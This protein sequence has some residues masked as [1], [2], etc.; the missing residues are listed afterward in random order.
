MCLWTAVKH[1]SSASSQKGEALAPSAPCALPGK[2]FQRKEEKRRGRGPRWRKGMGKDRERLEGEGN[3]GKV[4]SSSSALSL[5]KYSKQLC[6]IS[7]L[8]FLLA[9]CEGFVFSGACSQL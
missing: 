2:A 9:L 1:V 5:C 4:P 7:L 8:T 3:G 6:L